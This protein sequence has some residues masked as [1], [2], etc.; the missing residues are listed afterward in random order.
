MG[1]E[2]VQNLIHQMQEQIASTVVSLLRSI[3]A[4]IWSHF[5]PYII[6]FFIVILAGV[7]LQILMLKGGGNARLSPGF[8]RLL[9]SITYLFFLAL[10][11]LIAYLIWGSEVIDETWFVVFGVIAFPLTGLFLRLIGFWYY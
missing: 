6:G 4:L 1:P 11:A 5:W 2:F 3:T 9:G 7:I 10:V 8:N